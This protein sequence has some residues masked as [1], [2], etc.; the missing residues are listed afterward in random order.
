MEKVGVQ[1][2]EGGNSHLYKTTSQ[3]TKQPHALSLSLK[4]KKKPSRDKEEKGSEIEKTQ[5]KNGRV[6]KTPKQH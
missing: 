4:K 5:S 1:I 6:R 3:Q 2:K